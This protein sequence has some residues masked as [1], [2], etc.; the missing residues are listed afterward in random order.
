P[1]PREQSV[2]LQRDVFFTR[3]APSVR[4]ENDTLNLAFIRFTSGT[5]SASKGVALSHETIRDRIEAANE[6]L[7][8]DSNDIVIWCLPMSH[9]FLVTIMLYL[10]NGATIVLA[11]HLLARMFLETADRWKA[12]VLYAAPFHYSMMAR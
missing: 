3:L 4:D 9:H 8:I 10:A 6:V 11:R 5:T 12:T 1:K 2:S 7:K